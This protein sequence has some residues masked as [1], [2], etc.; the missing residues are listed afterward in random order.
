MNNSTWI[1]DE[2]EHYVASA[3]IAM[4]ETRILKNRHEAPCMCGSK[5]D[6]NFFREIG[7]FIPGVDRIMEVGSNDTYVYDQTNDGLITNGVIGQIIP[8]KKGSINGYFNLMAFQ[9]VDHMPDKWIRN[10]AGPLYKH[11]A[12]IIQNNGIMIRKN[13]YTIFNDV[14]KTC[15]IEFQ[16]QNRFSGLRS[17]LSWSKYEVKNKNTAELG[18]SMAMQFVADSRFCWTI[19]AEES[20]AKVRLGCQKEEI[21]SLLYARSLPMTETGRKRPVLHLVEA[22]KRRLKNGTDI[23]I[24]SFLRGSAKVEMNGTLFTV[25]P[26]KVMASDVSKNSQKYFAEAV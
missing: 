19:K 6:L 25:I 12:I 17:K 18:A 23:D 7:P 13:Y 22:H 24:T 20:E 16:S 21:K 5:K 4:Y 14:I 2:F 9:K 15:D 1:Q 8:E 26:P 10:T 11:L 3:L